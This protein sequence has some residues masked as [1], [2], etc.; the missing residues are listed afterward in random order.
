[1]SDIN[2]TIKKEQKEDYRIVEQ[3][4]REAFWNLYVP[5][6]SEHFVLHN[7]RNSSDFVSD[8]DFVAER[9]GQIVGQIAYT[10][11][12]VRGEG[13]NEEEVVSFGPLSVLPALQKQ[14]VG[15]A[16]VTHTIALARDMGYAAIC[17]YGGP[18]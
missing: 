18:R 13:T 14:G 12:V 3:L 7:L 17:I 4:V 5:G 1:M 10:R 16:L 11:G 9:E 2:L 8:L 6:C 15:S